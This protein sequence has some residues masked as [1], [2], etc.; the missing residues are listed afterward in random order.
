MN[1]LLAPAGNIDAFYAA[2]SNGADAIYVGLNS[3]SARA[4]ANNFDLDELKLITDYA[5]L[6]NV[7]IYV[8]MN[9]ILF[10][11]ELKMAFKTVDE[12]ASINVDAIIVQDLALLNYITSHYE[13]LT[14]ISKCDIMNLLQDS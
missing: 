12:L 6:R 8:A 1:E 14:F 4:Y 3:F 2:I 7:K 5:H 10:E 13:I 9:T 11:H